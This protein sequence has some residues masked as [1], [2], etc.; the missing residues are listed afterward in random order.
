MILRITKE[1]TGRIA[2]I[3]RVQVAEVTLTYQRAAKI[4]TYALHSIAATFPEA[5][6]Q[7]ERGPILAV[8]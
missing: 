5:H 8:R 7:S 1:H 4:G 6:I 3:T 2:L